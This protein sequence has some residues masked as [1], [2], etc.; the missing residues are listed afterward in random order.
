MFEAIALLVCFR[1]SQAAT[2]TSEVLRLLQ[3]LEL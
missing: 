1:L 2:A 3:K